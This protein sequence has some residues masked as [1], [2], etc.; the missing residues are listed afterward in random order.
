MCKAGMTPPQNTRA[1]EDTLQHQMPPR[2]LQETPVQPLRK[3]KIPVFCFLL[4]RVWGFLCF[5]LFFK[6][7]KDNLEMKME[8]AAHYT[9]GF[10]R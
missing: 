10:G 7:K 2:N 3:S 8:K 5:V 6:K 4:L 1:V 9:E